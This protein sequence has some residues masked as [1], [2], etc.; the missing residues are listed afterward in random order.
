[1]K[2]S[3][4]RFPTSMVESGMDM[5]DGDRVWTNPS[6]VKIATNGVH[7]DDDKDDF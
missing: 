4:G 5:K 1:M 6:L 2:K 3:F 7:V